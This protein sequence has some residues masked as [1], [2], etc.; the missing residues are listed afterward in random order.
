MIDT[1]MCGQFK[2]GMFT[3]SNRDKTKPGMLGDTECKQVGW[4]NEGMAYYNAL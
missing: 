2:D 1:N 3:A 4:S